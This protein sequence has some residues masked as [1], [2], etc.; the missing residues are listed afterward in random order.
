M[1][2]ASVAD[3]IHLNDEVKN[4]STKMTMAVVILPKT[5][6]VTIFIGCITVV[7]EIPRMKGLY[8][9][10]SISLIVSMIAT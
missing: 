1:N 9:M 8:L 7:M 10:L 4:R 5:F 2:A 6:R 3:V